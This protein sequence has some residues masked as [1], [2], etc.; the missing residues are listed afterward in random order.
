MAVG[1][2]EWW[3]SEL[4]GCAECL[5]DPWLFLTEDRVPCCLKHWLKLADSSVEWTM[6]EDKQ[7]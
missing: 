3:L 7:P 5:A 2:F 4:R 6:K 1:S